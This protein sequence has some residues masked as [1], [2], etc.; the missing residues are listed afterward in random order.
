MN[1]CQVYDRE[2]ANFLC[3][4]PEHSSREECRRRKLSLAEGIAHLSSAPTQ[5]KSEGPS[6]SEDVSTS[7]ESG[8]DT[9][10]RD[11]SHM[12]LT[13]SN[14]TRSA[15]RC[16]RE[17]ALLGLRDECGGYA[18]CVFGQAVGQTCPYGTLFDP[19]V[20]K[21]SCIWPSDATRPDCQKIYNPHIFPNFIQIRT[22]RETQ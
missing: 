3:V 14:D 4:D 21:K 18:V 9:Y 6:E 19:A 11:Y 12:F 22:N 8:A 20:H 15:G 7:K 13:P 17:G 10:F 1:S 16:E 2:G 5:I